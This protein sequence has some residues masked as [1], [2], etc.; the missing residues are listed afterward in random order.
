ML[1]LEPG[2]AFG[3]GTHETT[4]LCME[5]LEEYIFE[6]FDMPIHTSYELFSTLL[7]KYMERI[8]PNYPTLILVDM[9]SLME[10]DKYMEVNDYQEI[11][12]IDSVSTALALQVGDMIRKA[13]S[14]THLYWRA[15]KL[16]ICD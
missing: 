14:Y 11:G 12:I 8:N 7:K 5:M 1:H 6:A 10:I 2:L 3:T 15:R 13:V 16:T 4:R 9:G